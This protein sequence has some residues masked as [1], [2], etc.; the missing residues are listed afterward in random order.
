MPEPRRST[1][2]PRRWRLVRASG[3]AIPASVRRFNERARARRIAAARPWLL[4][5]VALVVLGAAAWVVFASSV[6]GVATVQVTGSGFVGASA[7]RDASG[8]RL[9]APLAT[10]DIDAVTARVRAIPAV[11]DV[12][13][14]R[15]FPRSVLIQVTL[16]QP[17]AAV[18]IGASHRYVQVDATGVPFRTVSSP[19]DLPVIDASAAAAADLGRDQ[20]RAS[21]AAAAQVVVAL[22]GDLRNL[23]LRVEAPSE[24]GVE[25]VL[26]DG[27]RIVWGDATDNQQ[28]ARVAE[29]LL[30]QPG[31]V[32]DVS[33]PGVVTVR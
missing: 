21:L 18:P 22:P 14:S 11:A 13:V 33:A 5:T 24:S 28:K 23:L 25:L 3:F 19:G 4:A 6:F 26:T 30:A 10:L 9:G 29:S 8:V 20:V 32:I 12:V 7:I 15:H 1:G 17:V 27:R 16:R 31:K 2:A